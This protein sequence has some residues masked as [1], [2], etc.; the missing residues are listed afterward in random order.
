MKEKPLLESNVIHELHLSH[1]CVFLRFHLYICIFDFSDEALGDAVLSHDL[2]LDHIDP[3]Q[4][5]IATGS[6]AVAHCSRHTSKIHP[7]AY[8]P[9]IGKCFAT[10]FLLFF[11][12]P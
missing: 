7:R 4:L 10:V 5:Y 6:G 8:L 11:A 3:N 9:E 12:L 1:Y 2:R